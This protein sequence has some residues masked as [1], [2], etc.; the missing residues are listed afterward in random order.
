MSSTVSDIITAVGYNLDVSI[1]SSSEPS[2]AEIIEWLNQDIMWILGICAEEGSDIGQ[3]SGTITASDGTSEYTDLAA[4]MYAPDD[5]GWV[6]SASA[7]TKIYLT[8]KEATIGFDP[9]ASN[10]G[11]PER[12]Y[13]DGSNSVHFLPTPDNTYTIYIPYWQVQTD[14][15]ATSDTVPFQELFDNILIQSLTI[16][17]QNRD[18]YDIQFEQSWLNFL[19]ERARNLIRMRTNARKRIYINR[20]KKFVSENVRAEMVGQG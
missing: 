11:Q 4:D 12:F 2:Q 13:V 7:R 8:T 15:T 14:L 5:F 10:E 3:T 16:R 6:E 1:D 18:E 19:T 9:G 20:S 17:A